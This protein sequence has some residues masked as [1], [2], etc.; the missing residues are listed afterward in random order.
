MYLD[1][2]Y[3]HFLGDKDKAECQYRKV[4]VVVPSSNQAGPAH[5][6]ARE[7]QFRRYHWWELALDILADRAR[8]VFSPSL[9]GDLNGVA[10]SAASR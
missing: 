8:W 10:I 3:E 5:C 9:S 4:E 7:P 2:L 1:Y 6:L